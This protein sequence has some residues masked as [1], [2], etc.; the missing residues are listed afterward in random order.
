MCFGGGR[1]KQSTR[2]P[3]DRALPDKEKGTNSGLAQKPRFIVS[4]FLLRERLDSKATSCVRPFSDLLEKAKLQ[5][6]KTDRGLAGWGAGWWAEHRGAA[7]GGGGEGDRLLRE[8]RMRNSVRPSKA[9]EPRTP[10]REHY[11]IYI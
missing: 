1:V 4:P 7:R 8:R 3:S 9:T 5:K 11:L 6:P 10:K 2:T